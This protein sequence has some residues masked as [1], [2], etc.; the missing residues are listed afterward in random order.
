MG[1]EIGLPADNAGDEGDDCPTA[2]PFRVRLPSI[3]NLTYERLQSDG[4][5]LMENGH[6]LF[7][8]IG[9][10]VNPAI[11]ST[12]FNEKS[13]ENVD[14]TTLSICAENSDF[15]SRVAA[16][17][18]ALRSDRKGRYMQLHF[19]REGDGYAEAYFARFL[20]EDRANFTGGN[21]TYN[22]YYSHLMRA[23]AGLPG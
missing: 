12:L 22:E 8:W 11:L 4:I 16:V 9:R 1:V 13:L 2:G 19:I 23:L 17:V 7:M 15:S 14:M 20:I 6:D 5:F 18:A 3:L 21:L 10:A